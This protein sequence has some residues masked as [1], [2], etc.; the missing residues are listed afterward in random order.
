M[1][2]GETRRVQTWKKNSA[3]SDQPVPDPV[4]ETVR[5]LASV[6]QVRGLQF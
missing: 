1:T 4:V 2:E 6:V 3:A 5:G